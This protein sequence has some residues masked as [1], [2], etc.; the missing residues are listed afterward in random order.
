[1]SKAGVPNWLIYK[2]CRV[3]CVGKQLAKIKT[4]VITLG[5]KHNLLKQTFS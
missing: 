2:R 5:L 3:L 1:M 4:K